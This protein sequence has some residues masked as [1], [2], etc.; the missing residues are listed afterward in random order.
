M[1]AIWFERFVA[2]IALFACLISFAA[3]GEASVES[4]PRDISFAVPTQELASYQTQRWVEPYPKPTL[5][6]AEV[7]RRWCQEYDDMLKIMGRE[8]YLSNDISLGHFR[9]ELWASYHE[10]VEAYCMATDPPPFSEFLWGIDP[11]VRLGIPE[12]ADLGN[13]G[14]VCMRYYDDVHLAFLKINS[15]KI[16]NEEWMPWLIA[17]VSTID[18]GGEIRGAFHVGEHSQFCPGILERYAQGYQTK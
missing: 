5:T 16:Q 4:D 1:K 17:Q 14:Q 11:Y 13:N 8:A 18:F 15:R 6:P 12:D 7:A 2:I 3:C 9:A 10:Q